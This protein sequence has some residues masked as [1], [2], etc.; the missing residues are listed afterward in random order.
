[1]VDTNDNMRH[2]S[3]GLMSSGRTFPFKLED[4]ERWICSPVGGDSGLR[5]AVQQPQRR[6]NLKSGPLGPTNS[7]YNSM[8]SPAVRMFDGEH[9]GSLLNG[10]SFS[11]GVNGGGLSV[12][13]YDGNDSSGN[14]P[15]LNE[16]CKFM[17]KHEYI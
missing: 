13:Y 14:F 8:Y 16:P 1:M 2:V 10:S 7:L 11:S 5:P 17:L 6:Q 12:R 3:S 15:S 4:V 9:V